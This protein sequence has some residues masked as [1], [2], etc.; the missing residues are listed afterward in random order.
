[1]SF[2]SGHP[3]I[4][5]LTF[6]HYC[7]QDRGLA[8]RHQGKLD[9]SPSPSGLYCCTLESSSIKRSSIEACR[10]CTEISADLL[11]PAM[12]VSIYCIRESCPGLQLCSLVGTLWWQRFHNNRCFICNDVVF[13]SLE[14]MLSWLHVYNKIVLMIF[15]LQLRNHGASPLRADAALYTSSQE[16]LHAV[17]LRLGTEGDTMEIWIDRLREWLAE[18]SH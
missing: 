1:M 15:C 10:P 2:W 8:W 4:L 7:H 11:W 12:C 5:D 9:G 3:R 16:T 6:H 14:R 13:G 17:M 18:V